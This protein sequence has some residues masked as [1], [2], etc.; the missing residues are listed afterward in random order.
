MLEKLSHGTW[1]RGVRR[2]LFSTYGGIARDP[3]QLP[4][5]HA[6]PTQ[7]TLHPGA[8]VLPV[9]AARRARVADRVRPSAVSDPRGGRF[10]RALLGAVARG[11]MTAAA[12]AAAAALTRRWSARV[13]GSRVGAPAA[14]ATTMGPGSRRNVVGSRLRGTTLPMGRTSEAMGTRTRPGKH[15]RTSSSLGRCDGTA[16]GASRRS[17]LRTLFDSA[18]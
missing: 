15:R 4:Q 5:T 13:R 3:N 10:A 8:S 9:A 6:P 11:A 7:Q 16:M 14:V 2:R 18:A 12:A 17:P 1:T